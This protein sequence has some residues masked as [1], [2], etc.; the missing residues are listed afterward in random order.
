MGP[1][2]STGARVGLIMST[3]SFIFLVLLWYHFEVTLKIC[4]LNRGVFSKIEHL[5]GFNRNPTLKSRL[6]LN[7][8]M[9]SLH[10]RMRQ[11][12]VHNSRITF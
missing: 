10:F 2:G 3:S 9:L 6:Y 12:V 1:P 7:L 11:G 8:K 4:L 5:F